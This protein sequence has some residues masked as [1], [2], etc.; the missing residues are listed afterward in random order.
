[1]PVVAELADI[2]AE[3]QERCEP[4]D[5]VIPSQRKERPG[6]G[7]VWVDRPSMKSSQQAVWRLVAKVGER[8]GIAEH[9]HPHMMRHA[10]ATFVSRHAGLREAQALLGHADV[11]TTQ[12]YVAAPTLDELREAI[13]GFGYHPDG[14][15]ETPGV[16]RRGFEP[17]FP[18]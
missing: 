17:L 6:P 18:P 15:P 4:L 11:S 13:Q 5:Y 1:M 10:F 14:G 8:A 16:A 3:I 2:V 7:R 9:V 12:G